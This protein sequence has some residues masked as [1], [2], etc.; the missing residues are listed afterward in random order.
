[1][2][3]LFIFA[4]LTGVFAALAGCGPHTAA[5]GTIREARAVVQVVYEQ[6]PDAAV[7]RLPFTAGQISPAVKR[8]RARLPELRPW[9]ESGAIG[10]ASNGLLR[11]RTLDGVAAEQHAALK[12]LL[13]AENRDR[14]TLYG[15][16]AEDVGHGNDMFGDTWMGYE[17]ATF[18]AEWI[19]QAPAGWWSQDDYRHW[20]QKK[21]A[22]AKA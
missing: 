9:L 2:R 14:L 18:A 1:M 15:A 5:A 16:H 12:T 4:G 19:G 22:P 13:K 20:T 6:L 21:T 10:V 17:G 8:L 3:R 11:I 7:A